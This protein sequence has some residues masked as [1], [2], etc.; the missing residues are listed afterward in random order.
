MK[1]IPAMDRIDE[2]LATAALNDKYVP[3]VQA[4]V[5]LGK[6]LLNKYYN[7]TDSSELYRIA[8][9]RSYSFL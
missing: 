6:N 4:A 2:T 8:M 1:V 5:T 9:S 3:A 7:L